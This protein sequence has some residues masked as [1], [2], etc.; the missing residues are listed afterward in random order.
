MRPS[1]LPSTLETTSAVATT[2]PGDGDATSVS[3]GSGLSRARATDRGQGRWLRAEPGGVGR[4]QHPSAHPHRHG[5]GSSAEGGGEVLERAGHALVDV[6]DRQILGGLQRRPQG[7]EALP[8]GERDLEPLGGHAG[9]SR[10]HAP[11]LRY[12]PLVPDAIFAHDDHH[13][14]EQDEAGEQDGQPARQRPEPR[15]GSVSSRSRGTPDLRHLT[16]TLVRTLGA[17]LAALLVLVTPARA[18]LPAPPVV[19]TGPV[20][21]GGYG[22]VTFGRPEH[23]EEVEGLEVSEAAAALM[24]WGQI[25]PRASY[26]VELDMAKRITETWTG[27]EASERL[28][29]VRLYMEYTASDLLRLRAGRFLTP[30]GQWNERHAEPLTWT[31]T[32]PLTTYRPF[33]KSLNGLL[34][35]GEGAL[36]GHDMGYAV[37]WAPSLRVKGVAEAEESSFVDAVGGRFAIEAHSGLTLGASAARIRRSQPPDP[38]ETQ[39]TEAEEREEEATHRTLLGADLR[40]ETRRFEVS[41]ETAWLPGTEHQVAEG[42]AF[43]LAAVRV[44]GPV[45]GVARTEYYRP[46]DD[47]T[48]RTAFAGLTLRAGPHL[49]VK[50]GRQFSKRPSTKIPDGWFLSFSSLF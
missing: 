19:G 15:Q 34:V 31:P 43:L 10:Q 21:I 36:A 9:T 16:S 29:P 30:I 45:W 49:V 39:E 46:V 41:A 4:R 12:Q 20:Q 17:A 40:W 37:F 28:V 24:A 25:A 32:R 23:P 6:V 35:A 5:F 13:R 27:R 1:T 48:A 44:A 11:G 42:G 38:G 22:S 33:A 8:L 18:Q 7:D 3:P 50:F 26:F 14:G 47:R 2:V